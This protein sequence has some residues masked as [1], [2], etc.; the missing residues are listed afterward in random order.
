MVQSGNVMAADA[1]VAGD[2]REDSAQEA[3]SMLLLRDVAAILRAQRAV[4]EVLCGEVNGTS[5]FVE[6]RVAAICR[7]LGR[8][9]PAERTATPE[10]H[11]AGSSVVVDSG[12]AHA[13]SCLITEVQF[14]DR[15][16]QRLQ[17][18]TDTLLA[19]AECADEAD[20]AIAAGLHDSP[21]KLPEEFIRFTARAAHDALRQ[22]RERIA[23]S[24]PQGGP[25]AVYGGEFPADEGVV[26]LF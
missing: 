2:P 9:L 23:A 14:Q 17:F 13:V 26:D 22:V 25:A 11:V 12:I 8:L 7:Q 21:G 18:V 5:D 20:R 6:A 15:A 3:A 4:L 24:V 1:G 10:S 19:L 16:R